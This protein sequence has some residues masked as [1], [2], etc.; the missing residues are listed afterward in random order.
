MITTI[1]ESTINAPLEKVFLYV[2][3]L[4]T[5]V[6]YNS[7]VKESIWVIQNEST[8]ISKIKISLSILNFTGEY[9]ISEFIKNS[10]IVAKCITP[11]IEFEDTY[12]F[13]QENGSTILKIEDRMQLKGLLSFSEGI[14]S[15][16]M[17]QEM[18]NNLKT[19]ISI[20]ETK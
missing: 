4:E 7:S 20:L 13:Y 8:K 19:L 9:K 11:T 2:A 5:M 14:V 12:S 6:N 10:K 18:Q 3:D 16:I 1:V 15:P 17:K